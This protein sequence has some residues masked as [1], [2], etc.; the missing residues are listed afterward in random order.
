MKKILKILIV[1][2]LIVI[3]NIALLYSTV[4]AVEDGSEITIYTKGYFNRIIKKR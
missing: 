3:S 2:T 1:F 4:Q